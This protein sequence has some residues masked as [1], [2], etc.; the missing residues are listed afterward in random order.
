MSGERFKACLPP[1]GA[2]LA[3][4]LLAAPA[5]H[6]ATPW[7]LSVSEELTHDSNVFRSSN[8]NAAADTLSNTGLRLTLDQ[9]LGR[10]LWNSYAA[11]NLE[12]YLD[13]SAW[14]HL[15]Y[16]VG[17]ELD[18]SAPDLWQGELGASAS[19]QLYR[20][21]Q[22]VAEPQRNLDRA[23]RAWLRARKGVVTDWTFEL[24]VNGF[25][26]DLSLASSDSLDQRQGAL[27]AGVGFQPNPDLRTRLLA[28]R[29]VGEY[30]HLSSGDRD[31][32]TRNDLELGM[33]WQPSGASTLAGRV[34]WGREDHSV[35]SQ[36]SANVWAGSLAWRWQP[37]GKLNFETR[38]Q[39]DNDTGSSR[40]QQ[41][42]SGGT[43]GGGSGGGSGNND[44]AQN[45]D[46]KL[47]TSGG[48]TAQWALSALWRLSA[49]ASLTHR[50]LDSAA[51]SVTGA[52]GTDNTRR[53]SLGFTYSPTRRI[54]LGCTVSRER[55]TVSAD[56]GGL[57]FPYDAN[58]AGCNARWWLGQH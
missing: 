43:S 55:R 11:V 28:R 36:R 51:S 26:R 1:L 16:D 23:R 22:D 25:Q 27:E 29:T 4:L 32:Y 19:Q 20:A 46:A 35:S 14:N 54:D 3:G 21:D 57:S 33:D 6:A 7:G 12:R 53:L 52:Q 48:L 9:P 24:A 41:A 8:A 15:A 37:T 18:W 49:A 50:S 30:P 40:F 58:S 56:V 17:S 10:Q 38:L 2:A 45:T 39:R 13:H 31:H 5:A 47:S 42:S 34:A 44:T